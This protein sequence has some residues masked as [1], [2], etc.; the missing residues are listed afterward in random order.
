MRAYE[1]L[2][3]NLGSPYPGTWEEENRKFTVGGQRRVGDLTEETTT[4]KK[5]YRYGFPDQDELLWQFI[6]TG[7][8]NTP[9]EIKRLIPQ[10]LKQVL[11]IQYR[12]EDIEDL[13]DRLE[14]NQL[15][16]LNNY[17]DS[18]LSNEI[19]VISDGEIVD[20]NHRAL[21]AAFTN[22]SIKYV[23]LSDLDNEEVV[24]EKWSNKYKSSINCNNP[25]GFS[26]RAHCQG[27]KK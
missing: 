18:D 23:D 22:K 16:T 25:K 12:V 17:K 24:N 9:L 26:Q 20:G 14:P 2:N 5:V 1:F 4:L 27:K 13:L 10:V 15:E 19:I 21:A 11:E 3:E 6:G 7:D 8:L